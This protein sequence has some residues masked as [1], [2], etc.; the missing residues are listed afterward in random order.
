MARL[1]LRCVV[2]GEAADYALANTYCERQDM[3]YTV[4]FI[5]KETDGG[6]LLTKKALTYLQDKAEGYLTSHDSWYVSSSSFGAGRVGAR[7]IDIGTDRRRG[8]GVVIGVARRR[9]V[10]PATALFA[11][12]RAAR[13]VL[14]LRGVTAAGHWSRCR[15]DGGGSATDDETTT[16]PPR[17]QAQE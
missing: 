14:C 15:R 17:S 10:G 7:G 6:N 8:G 11:A 9:H 1:A 3:G 2:L 16:T 4:D 13:R 12:T 5:M